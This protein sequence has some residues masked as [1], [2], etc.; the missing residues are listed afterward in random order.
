MGKRRCLYLVSS[1]SSREYVADCLEALALPRGMVHHFRYRLRHL[2]PKL[3]KVLPGRPGAL[4]A[5]YQGMDVMVVFLT[6][7]RKPDESWESSKNYLPLRCGHL[8]DAFRDGGVAHFY[9]EVGNYFIYRRPIESGQLPLEAVKFKEFYGLTGPSA[10]TGTRVSKDAAAFQSFVENAYRSGEWRTVSTGGVPLDITYDVLFF[11]IVGVFHETKNKEGMPKLIE[12]KPKLKVVPGIPYAEY[13]LERRELYRIKICTYHQSLGPA[14]LPGHGRARLQLRFDDRLFDSP[15]PTEL[16]VSSAYDLQYW[17]VVPRRGD[18]KSVLNV[19]CREGD[20][21]PKESFIHR[22][23][24]AA[25]VSL[26]VK[27]V[28]G[29]RIAHEI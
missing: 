7:T 22:E 27:L 3:A 18:C 19:N 9:F 26:P 29:R 2:D 12:V 25:E 20:S 14:Q 21:Q 11:R 17:A 4:A 13:S 16:T 6:V 23:L 28:A 1:S 24:V 10:S 8:I 5:E 15:G